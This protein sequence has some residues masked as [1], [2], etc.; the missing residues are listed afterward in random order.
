L[1]CI[2]NCAID[3][4]LVGGKMSIESVLKKYGGQLMQIPNVTAVGIGEKSGKE[5]ILV[6]VRK[7]I[8]ESA[9]QPNETIP[10][11]LDGYPT[12]VHEEIKVY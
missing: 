11:E 8:P 9:L 6:F 5:V 4:A 12:D 3:V 10:K 1:N 2:E 7:K